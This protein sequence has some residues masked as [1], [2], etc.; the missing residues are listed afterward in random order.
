[1]AIAQQH[2]FE[3]YAITFRCGQRHE[4]EIE[5]ARRIAEHMRV[6]QHVVVDFDL[7]LFGGSV[8]TG[9]IALPRDRSVQETGG[10]ESLRR[11]Q[12]VGVP[13]LQSVR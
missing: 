11:Q 8:L 3:S 4:Y 13:L 12:R 10:R 6:A 9:D 5:A 7:R 1:L 2:G